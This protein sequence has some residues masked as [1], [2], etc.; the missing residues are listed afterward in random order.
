MIKL[1]NQYNS[2]N[3]IK[4]M[5]KLKIIKEEYGCGLLPV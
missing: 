2:Q 5:I 1:N 4:M 3:E